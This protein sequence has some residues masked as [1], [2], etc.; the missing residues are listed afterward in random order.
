MRISQALRTTVWLAAV[1][2]CAQEQKPPVK[3]APAQPATAPGAPATPAVEIKGLPPRVAPSDYQAHTQV[4]SVTLAADFVE[5]S[6]PTPTGAF[7]TEDYVIVEAGFYGPPEARLKLSVEDF[8]IR[9]NGKRPLPGKPYGMVLSNVKDP[10]WAPPDPPAPKGGKT[11]L[12]TGGGEPAASGPPPIVHMPMPLQHAME[13]K[14]I[15]AA[16]PEGD[17]TLPQAGLLFFNYRGQTKGIQS[18]ELIYSGP[19]GKATLT[20]QP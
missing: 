19:A 15:K 12:T 9:I 8:S 14:V 3:D 2:L 7:S 13:Q 4:G 1:C 5:H 17:R 11:G 20:L 18:V 6:I 10:E 16:M